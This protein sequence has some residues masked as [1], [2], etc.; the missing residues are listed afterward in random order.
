MPHAQKLT[1]A[2]CVLALLLVAP[3]LVAA[4]RGGGKAFRI[5]YACGI[6]TRICVMDT[7]GAHQRRLTTGPGRSEAPDWSPDGKLIAFP[8]DRDGNAELYVMNADGSDQRRLTNTPW[9][10]A[11]P[12]WSPDGKKLAY[13]DGRAGNL[14]IYVMD[15]D[16]TNR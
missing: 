1:T 11:D 14:E 7:N 2:G 13:V 10:E 3:P 16:G 15:A 8:S 6:P 12:K 5:A 9:D 4:G